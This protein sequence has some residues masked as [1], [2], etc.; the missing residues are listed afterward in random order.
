MPQPDHVSL[1]VRLA[2]D[3]AIDPSKGF[4]KDTGIGHRFE[5]DAHAHLD[6]CQTHGPT[7]AISEQLSR[8]WLLA[9]AL[10][11]ALA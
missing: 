5:R 1:A 8:H 7:K 9:L 4:W 11:L 3:P 10:A 6:A 2:R